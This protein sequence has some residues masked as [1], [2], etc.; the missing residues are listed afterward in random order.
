MFPAFRLSCD[1]VL[2]EWE[3]SLSP[4]GCVE[5][6]VWPSITKITSDAVARTLFSSNYEE[7]RRIFELQEEQAEY[8]IEALRSIYIPGWR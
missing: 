3:R 8:A 5:L 7:G 4:E 1:E 2:S 6:D